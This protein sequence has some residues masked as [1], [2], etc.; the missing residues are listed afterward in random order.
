[1]WFKNI[2]CVVEKDEIKLFD[3]LGMVFKENCS[4]IK[5]FV[6]EFFDIESI[7]YEKDIKVF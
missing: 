5:D 1:M 4:G 6:K 2:V 7:D 3:F